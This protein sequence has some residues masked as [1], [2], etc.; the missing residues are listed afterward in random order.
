VS[1]VA[2]AAYR[3]LLLNPDLGAEAV[4]MALE[5]SVEECRDV[6][7]QLT[8]RGMIRGEVRGEL[9]A[10]DPAVVIERLVEARL[11]VLH[12]D[13]QNVVASRH[14]VEAL[15]AEQRKGRE[16]EPVESLERIEGLDDVRQRIDELTFFTHHEMLSVHPNVAWSANAIAAT[17]TP[18][19]RCVR[20][21][22]RMRSIVRT[23]AFEDPTT[24]AYL[25]ELISLG[26]QVRVA[27]GGLERMMIFDQKVA[28]VPFD[29]ASSSRGALLIR[30]PGL[31]SNLLGYFEQMWGAGMDGALMVAPSDNPD[32]ITEAEQKLLNVMARVDKDEIGARELG[33]SVRTYRAHTARLMQ[34]L[35][36]SNRFQAALRAREMGWI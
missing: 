3:Y 2:E 28:L 34:R 24:R 18:D 25:E 19:L 1:P 26:V 11:R 8:A 5:L 35:N 13:L 17:R 16:A 31:V 33:I 9:T 23:E 21:G 10:V 14:L 7:A 27:P 4:A 20:R 12:D 22:I 36:A 29:P 6:L 15:L 30:Q 32:Q